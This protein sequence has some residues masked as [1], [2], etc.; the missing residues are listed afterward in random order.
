M[1]S[2]P[3][4]I[5][6]PKLSKPGEVKKSSLDSGTRFYGSDGEVNITQ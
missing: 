4:A 3:D 6:L 1:A 2:N 5:K